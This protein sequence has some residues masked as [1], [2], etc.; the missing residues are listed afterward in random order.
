LIAAP[1]LVR[2]LDKFRPPYNM[3]SLSQELATV[4]VSELAPEIQ[5]IVRSVVAERARVAEAINALPGLDVTPSQANFLWVRTDEPAEAVF[6]NLKSRGILVRSFHARGGRLSN[7]LRVTIGLASE[8]D[9]LLA[10][11]R[12]RLTPCR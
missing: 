2:E 5:R 12:D 4:V 9:A 7:Q 8:N 10:A 3:C 11:L 1:E 6:E